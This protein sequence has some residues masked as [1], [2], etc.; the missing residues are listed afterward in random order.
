MAPNS[1]AM[2]EPG[3]DEQPTEA[4]QVRIKVEPARATTEKPLPVRDAVP[5]MSRRPRGT[6]PRVPP[7]SV[8][9]LTHRSPRLTACRPGIAAGLRGAARS[10]HLASG[11]EDNRTKR[12]RQPMVSRLGGLVTSGDYAPGIRQRKAGGGTASASVRA[13]GQHVPVGPASR[14]RNRTSW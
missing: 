3:P 14:Y 6:S 12:I 7:M 2:H 13:E 10:L 4:G 1:P 5:P 11:K 8:T 9:A